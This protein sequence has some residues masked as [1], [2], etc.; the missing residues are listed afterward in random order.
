MNSL[1]IRLMI[2]VVIMKNSPF[3]TMSSRDNEL[4]GDKAYDNSFNDE[5]LTL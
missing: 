2:I 1:V 4:I 5:K 3:E